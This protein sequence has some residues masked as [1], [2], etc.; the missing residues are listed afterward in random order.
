MTENQSQ[1]DPEIP[2]SLVLSATLVE[3]TITAMLVAQEAMDKAMALL[4]RVRRGEE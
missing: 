3:Q 1:S 2:T 4:R